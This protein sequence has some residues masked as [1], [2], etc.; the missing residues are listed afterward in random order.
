MSAPCGIQEVRDDDRQ[1]C[2]DAGAP[3]TAGTTGSDRWCR[4]SPCPRAA[5][6]PDDPPLA[7]SGSSLDPQPFV[8]GEDRQPIE[9]R[10]TDVAERRGEPS[11][12]IE[13]R[14]FG[15]RAAGVDHD[16]D[17]QVLLL[18]EQP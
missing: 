3:R 5:R 16:V 1:A 9:M 4:P 7:A 18:V 14:R 8:K 15:H 2:S 13:L 11:R 6:T 10:E 12:Q 17:R